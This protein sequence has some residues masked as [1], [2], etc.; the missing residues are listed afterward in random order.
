MVDTSQKKQV[1]LKRFTEFDWYGYAGAVSFNKDS[2]PFIGNNCMIEVI[3]DKNGLRVNPYYDDEIVI[4]GGWCLHIKTDSDIEK[5]VMMLA[6][7]T[8]IETENCFPVEINKYL[9]EKGFTR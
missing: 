7:K 5:I 4:S 9:I 8:L 6:E 3:A 1:N 2:E